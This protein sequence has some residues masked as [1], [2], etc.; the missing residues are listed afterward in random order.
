LA[1]IARLAATSPAIAPR[2][3]I[4]RGGTPSDRREHAGERK[5]NGDLE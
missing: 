5:L 4:R 1:Q 3:R 2:A